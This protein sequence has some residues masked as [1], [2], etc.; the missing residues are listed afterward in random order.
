MSFGER[1][2]RIPTQPAQIES[3]E[4]RF[5]FGE[6]WSDFLTT[7]DDERIS[8]A[9]Q[10]LVSLLGNGGL[11]NKS[12]L[13]LGCG[14]GLFSLAARR[15]GARVTSFD[16]DRDSV[17]CAYQLKQRYYP[18]DEDWTILRGSALDP[19]FVSSIGSFDVTYAWGVLHHTGD[20]WK[21][22][23]NIVGTVVAD[24]TLVVS[25][26]NDQGWISCYWRFIKRM[27][28]KFQF[29]RPILAVLYAPYFIGLR[30]LVR[31]LRGHKQLDR[32]MSYWHDMVDWLGGYPFE[33]AKPDRVFDFYAARGFKLSSL[34]TCG[35][36]SGC[37]EFVFQRS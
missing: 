28:N 37:N 29:A 20:M 33:V 7:V 8:R 4:V 18:A 27:Y 12:F 17:D 31:S 1:T 24:G 2:K 25:I 34:K 11:V 26:Y 21:A 13:D 30:F 23:E 15:L 9:Q 19:E 3:S 14:S 5:R 6:N 32:G 10:S 36:R 22:M 16:Y 35:G